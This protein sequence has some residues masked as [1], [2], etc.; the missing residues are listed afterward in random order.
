VAVSAPTAAPTVA[1]TVMA[2]RMRLRWLVM[3]PTFVA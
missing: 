1:M 2:A 3:S